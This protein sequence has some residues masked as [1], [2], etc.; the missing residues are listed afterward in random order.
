MNC[1]QCIKF[2]NSDTENTLTEKETEKQTEKQTEKETEKETEKQTEQNYSKKLIDTAFEM[3]IVI[4]EPE[5]KQVL[6]SP[7]ICNEMY[8]THFE[9]KKMN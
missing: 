6:E 7:I 8:I 4:I 5:H 2:E 1:L 9:H 3:D